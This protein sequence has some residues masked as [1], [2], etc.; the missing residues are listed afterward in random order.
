MT[1]A[2]LLVS[3]AACAEPRVAR[4]P[5][6]TQPLVH[7]PEAIESVKPFE[8]STAVARGSP[9]CRFLMGAY[10]Y[11]TLSAA[12]AESQ[13]ANGC[14]AEEGASQPRVVCREERKLDPDDPGSHM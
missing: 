12:C 9:E 2:I 7:E 14:D 3:L 6:E 13:C 10:C 1:R 5:L 11:S 4:P 8:G